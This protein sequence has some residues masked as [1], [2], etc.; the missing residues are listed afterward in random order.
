MTLHLIGYRVRNCGLIQARA[1]VIPPLVFTQGG[2]DSYMV[3]KKTVPVSE[4]V[5]HG[6]KRAGAGRKPI[7]P[8]GVLR[9]IFTMTAYHEELLAGLMVKFGVNNRSAVVRKLL[10]DASRD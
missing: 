4:P 8:G 5:T 2:T 1:G 3:K 7:S 10:E 6:G 9:R